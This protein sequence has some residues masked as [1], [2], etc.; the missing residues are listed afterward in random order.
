M[1]PQGELAHRLVKRFYQRTNK[2]DAIRQI[3]RLERRHVR[4]RR[5]KEA[6]ASPRGRH[7][8]HVAFSANDPLPHSGVDLHHHMS[9]SKNFPFHLLSFVHQP[10][11]DP[12]KKVS[13]PILK[14]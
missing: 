7:A 13:L 3:A 4:L 11:Y 1:T 8:H 12:A 6:A 5:A 10:P 2:K 9:D 14:S